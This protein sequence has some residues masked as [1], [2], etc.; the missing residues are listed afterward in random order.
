M[1]HLGRPLIKQSSFDK[2]MTM[3]SSPVASPEE[4]EVGPRRMTAAAVLQQW[5]R[6]RA[7]QAKL[8]ALLAN[9]GAPATTILSTMRRFQ[10][11]T[12]AFSQ[13]TALLGDAVFSSALAA[14]P[15]DPSLKGKNPL[16]RQ[17]RTFASALLVAY[18][19]SEVLL[20]EA[21]QEDTTTEVR[22]SAWVTICT[23]LPS[24]TNPCYQ[25]RRCQRA[26]TLLVAR[27]SRFLTIVGRLAAEAGGG[28]TALPGL[29]CGPGPGQARRVGGSELRAVFVGWRF[30]VRSFVEALEAWKVREGERWGRGVWICECV[31]V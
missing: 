28:Q 19:P 22:R 11:P 25:A 17:P 7:Q 8:R 30:A 16:A 27:S 3:C 12:P 14:L 29:G 18:H 9:L 6:A 4:E 21:D 23:M 24:V 5:A 15:L 31:S 26:A 2:L 1:E 20:D 13:C 10:P